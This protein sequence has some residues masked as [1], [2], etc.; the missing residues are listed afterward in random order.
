MQRNTTPS[1]VP[2]PPPAQQPP[3]LEHD[4]GAPDSGSA[5]GWL[6]VFV[7]AATVWPW[8]LMRF[9]TDHH[10]SPPMLVAALSGLAILGAAFLLSW[11]AEAFQMDVSQALALALLSLI[12]V[13]PEYAV[14]VVFAWRAAH[15]PTQASYAVAN[16]TGANRLL[17]GVGWSLVVLVA[18]WRSKA[19]TP[20]QRASRR[21]DMVG[22]AVVLERGQALE[23]AALGAATLYSF[24]LPL[25]GY[26]GWGGIG[27]IDTV[28]LVSLFAVYAWGTSRAPAEDPHLVGPAA[29]IG[30]LAPTARRA[31]T[32][33]LFVYAAAAIFISAE[34]FAE[35]LVHSG[36]ALGVDEFL[37]VQWLAPFASEAPEFLVALLF[38]WRGL[39]R[40]GLRTL[41]ASKVNQWTLLIGT[42]GA[43]YSIA[44]GRPADL[45]L[46]ARQTEELFLTSAQSLFALAVIANFDMSVREAWFLL[47]TFLLQLISPVFFPEFDLEMRVGFGFLYIAGAVW[48][49]ASDRRRRDTIMTIPDMVM[50]AVGL[51]P[52]IQT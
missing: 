42:L 28:V 9:T 30:A 41:V 37:L 2:F 21:N 49:I 29:T 6:W 18:Y 36:T 16:M 35:G 12:A 44:L 48:L 25:K 15:D 24:F 11:A 23:I 1:I 4:Y 38:A 7:A 13:L 10:A 17:I 14:D 22:D 26:F 19:G 50:E 8:L 46:D 47:S 20:A 27:L 43:A 34:P 33:G 5:S 31:M 45:P 40:A 32:Y 52:R 51:R 3:P 39:A